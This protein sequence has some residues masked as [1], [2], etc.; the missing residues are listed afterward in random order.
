M[1]LDGLDRQGGFRIRGAEIGRLETLVY[2]AFAFA[3]TLLVVSVGEPPTSFQALLNAMQLIPAFAVS[4]VL[5]AIFWRAYAQ[6]CRRFGMEDGGALVLGLMLIFSVLVFVY[7]LRAMS[8]AGMAW[9]TGGGLPAEFEL[10]GW[11][12][13][14][15]LFMVYGSAYAVLAALI[16]AHY[17][18]ALRHALPLALDPTELAICQAERALWLQHAAVGLGSVL[19]AWALPGAWKSVAPWTYML[20]ALFGVRYGRRIARAAS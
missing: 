20:L 3:L 17:Q 6:W 16:A 4:F 9:I 11:A 13:L 8:I 19:L 2:S 10:S 15:G 5:L 14:G 7:P 12:D 18:W 1:Q